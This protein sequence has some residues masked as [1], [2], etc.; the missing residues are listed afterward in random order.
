MF[1]FSQRK[2]QRFL[3][4]KGD[5]IVKCFKGLFHLLSMSSGVP[6]SRCAVRITHVPMYLGIGEYLEVS[7]LL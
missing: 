7:S 3:R 5:E 2:V 1:L 6:N 4:H